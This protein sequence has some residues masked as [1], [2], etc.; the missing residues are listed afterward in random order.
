M[1]K[2]FEEAKRA[3]YKGTVEDFEKDLAD[4]KRIIE[5]QKK[6]IENDTFDKRLTGFLNK[7]LMMLYVNLTCVFNMGYFDIFEYIFNFCIRE[8]I[9]IRNKKTYQEY[10]LD[11]KCKEVEDH[12]NS[13]NSG[14][15]S[16]GSS[17]G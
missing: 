5:A 1:F 2:D 3:G 17:I 7:N 8:N 11:I 13:D 6:I 15:A 12:A 4:S 10:I 16:V 9:E 14:S